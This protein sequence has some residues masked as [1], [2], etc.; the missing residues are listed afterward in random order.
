MPANRK[1]PIDCCHTSAVVVDSVA[2]TITSFA[3]RKTPSLTAIDQVVV[4]CNALTLGN[5]RQISIVCGFKK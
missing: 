1:N 3:G 5:E 4:E 2:Y